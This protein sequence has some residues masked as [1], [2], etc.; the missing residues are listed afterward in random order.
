[1]IAF[2]ALLRRALPLLKEGFLNGLE[3]SAKFILSIRAAFAAAAAA[4]AAWISR[5]GLKGEVGAES[6]GD[7]P[8]DDFFR[9][10]FNER[11]ESCARNNS[12]AVSLSLSSPSSPCPNHHLYSQA[13]QAKRP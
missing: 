13:L 8:P 1:M 10:I 5:S 4:F 12:F 9:G 6:S 2:V 11:V 7:V 3:A